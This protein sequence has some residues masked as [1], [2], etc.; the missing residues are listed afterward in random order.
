MYK[1]IEIKLLNSEVTLTVEYKTF[2]E[3][4]TS[5]PAVMEVGYISRHGSHLKI[6]SVFTESEI[7][8]IKDL[9]QVQIDECIKRVGRDF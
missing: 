9:V 8:E 3:N 7:D 5:E 6:V 1:D 2:F 4:D